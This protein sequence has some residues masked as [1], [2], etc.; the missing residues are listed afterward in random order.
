MTSPSTPHRTADTA[1]EARKVAFGA[2]VGTALE[3]YDFFLYGTAA[4]LVFNRV[5]F[6][7]DNPVASTMAAF[8]S[9]GVGFAARPVG[10]VIFGRM[11]DKVG[12]KKTLIITVIMIGVATALIGLLP[13]YVTI[14]VAAPILLTLLRLVQGLAVGGEWGGAVTLA[15]EHAPPEQRGRFGVMPQI[16]SPVGTL[17]SSGAFLAVGLLPQEDFM[18]WGW[19]LPF[20]AAI[21][22]LA[23]ALYL[24]V[25]IEESPLFE[26]M[27]KEEELA[28]TPVR[29]VFSLTR[30]ELLI[31][32]GSTLLGV[33]GFYL[34]TTFAIAYGTGTLGLP[35]SLLLGATL[36]AAAVEIVILIAF[37]RA[38]ERFGAGRVTLLGGV[39]SALVAI[40]AFL[41]LDTR[42]PAMVV[43]AIVI[44]VALLSIPYAA[45]GVLLTSLFPA[46]LRYSGVALASNIG[47][48]VSGFVPFAAT[49][50]YAATGNSSMG[51][52]T[53]LILLSLVTAGSGFLASRRRDATA[54]E[55]SGTTPSGSPR[56]HA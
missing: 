4:S 50:A 27:L 51:P 33:G 22:L 24:R 34:V 40:P 43:L 3:W 12:R 44:A 8:A 10:A 2:F 6:V 30:R 38:V 39:L 41:M 17:L 18:S 35:R 5:F 54:E 26:V 15:I 36:A 7:T 42:N 52:A 25:K 21:P 56:R 48:V 31:G 32:A 45:S 55:L 1:A 23:I 14:G 9:F 37:G 11:G 29:D 13:S 49:W 28:K 20:L 19:R 46:N 47:A 16:G 53:L